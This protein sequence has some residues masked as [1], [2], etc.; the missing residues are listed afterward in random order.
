MKF[1]RFFLSILL[2][3]IFVL[4]TYA[5]ISKLSFIIPNNPLE[6][7]LYSFQIYFNIV[8]A[9]IEWWLVAF[10]SFWIA[11]FA[12]GMGLIPI[13]S[14]P[15][16]AYRFASNKMTRKGMKNYLISILAYSV[17][18]AFIGFIVHRFMYEFLM[19]HFYL[20][21]LSAAILG[22]AFGTIGNILA[23]VVNS[24]YKKT[25]F[26]YLTSEDFDI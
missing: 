4:I 21:N 26:W 12:L 2:P 18:F 9:Y 7:I 11:L 19:N 5:V 23:M 10:A 6:A 17:F 14:F 25:L 3:A 1:F 22:C 13:L 8:W 16:V 20:D 15:Y 24:D